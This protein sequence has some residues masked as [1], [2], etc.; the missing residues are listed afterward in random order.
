MI[1][2]PGFLPKPWAAARSSTPRAVIS[3]YVVYTVVA[4]GAVL[5][6]LQCYFQYK[7]VALDRQPLCLVFEE[8]F[9]NERQVFGDVG[10]TGG[11]FMREV[12]MDGFGFVS[13]SNSH[14]MAYHFSDA[15][16]TYQ[17]RGI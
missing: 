4:V 17:E 13:I 10:T 9:D 7:G 11:S 6:A 2:D 16:C 8:N 15:W 1:A 14:P 12:N 5:G 3:Y